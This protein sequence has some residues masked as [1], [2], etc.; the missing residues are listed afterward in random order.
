MS[1]LSPRHAHRVHRYRRAHRLHAS[2]IA[3]H[4]CAASQ[5]RANAL[6]LLRGELKK[7]NGP[8][9]FKNVNKLYDMLADLLHDKHTTTRRAAVAAAADAVTKSGRKG[10]PLLL[11]V[12]PGL[13]YNLGD[14]KVAVRGAAAAAIKVILASLLA[15]LLLRVA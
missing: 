9:R 1:N 3:T 15:R 12:L 8:P 6:E 7:A 2:T 13:I 10:G 4:V 5:E 11:R 14:G